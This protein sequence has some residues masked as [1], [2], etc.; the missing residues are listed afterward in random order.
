MAF[1][2]ETKRK[3][4]EA[5]KLYWQRKKGNSSAN[6]RSEIVRDESVSESLSQLTESIVKG[7][8]KWIGFK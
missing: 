2:Q 4:S 8:M 7:F 1:S 6:H 5:R 3:M